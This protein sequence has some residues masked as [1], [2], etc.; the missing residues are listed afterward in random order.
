MKFKRFLV[1]F[2]VAAITFFGSNFA[3][4]KLQASEKK[5]I[6]GENSSFDD[7]AVNTNKNE[8]L[9]L[10]VGVDK[11]GEDDNQDFTRTDTIMLVKTNTQT[12]KV[13]IL[14]VP[15]DSRVKIR[16]EFDKVNHAHA[17]GGIELTVQTLRNFL[18]L[19]I[20]YYVEVNYDAIEELVEDMGGVDF[21]VPKGVSIDKGSVKIREGLNHFDKKDVIWY[22]RTRNIYENGDIGRVNAQ[23]GFLKAMVDQVVEKS[24]QL[25]LISLASNFMR[26]VKTNVP[27][28]IMINHVKNIKNFS[29]DKVDTYTIPGYEQGID[30]VS[31]YLVDFEKAY[32]LVDKHFSGFKLKNWTKEK[33]GLD[34]DNQ[35]IEEYNEAPPANSYQEP[36]PSQAGS[37]YNDDQYYDQNYEEDVEY[38][39]YY[40]EVPVTESE[41]SSEEV[42]EQVPEEVIEEVEEVPE[43]ETSVEE[44]VEE[45]E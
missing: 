28:S 40:I 34:E 3:L 42:I 10:V 6:Y 30:G 22:L 7:D 41:E 8:H 37:T 13:D 17:Y 27:L 39:Y 20:D 45:T 24:D 1:A 14:S 9:I 4:N 25:D 43:E 31:Y 23:Q 36:D 18:G 11:N 2:L 5:K 16:E 12:G 15:R 32:D 44:S 26:N 21:V 19:D 38:E 33:A 35:I 29:S